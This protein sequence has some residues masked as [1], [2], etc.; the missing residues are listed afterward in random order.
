M[1][2]PKYYLCSSVIVHS[3]V[4]VIF[5]IIAVEANHTCNVDM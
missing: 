3:L 5:V 1:T 2:T 4:I